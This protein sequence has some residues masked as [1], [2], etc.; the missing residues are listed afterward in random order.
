M[1]GRRVGPAVAVGLAVAV[2]VA[3]LVVAMTRGGDEPRTLEQRVQAIAAELRCPVCQNLSVADSPSLVA[4]QIRQD[5]ERRLRS[6]EDPAEV[7]AAFVAR[8]GTWI[9]LTPGAG[10]LGLVV[11][12]APVA[13]IAVGALVAGAFLRRRRRGVGG[14]ASGR[15]ADDGAR[16]V[17]DGPE[18]IAPAT[19]EERARIRRE[20]ALLEERE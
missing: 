7:R 14:T 9:D 2:A 5:I 13:A 4:R 3:A 20:L 12:L 19:R 18:V 17:A 15:H 11:W 1:R 16:P 10:G 8:Y 6:G